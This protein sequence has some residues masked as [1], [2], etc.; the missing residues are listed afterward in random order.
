MSNE[1]IVIVMLGCWAIA[2]IL[3]IC[4]TIIKEDDSINYGQLLTPTK[5]TALVV[6]AWLI[7]MASFSTPII[8]TEIAKCDSP[9]SK[10]TFTP[11]T[12]K[13]YIEHWEKVGCH[14]I[15]YYTNNYTINNDGSI[16][17]HQYWYHCLAGI[18]AKYY[19]NDLIIYKDCIFGEGD[20]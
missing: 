15:R 16:T 12:A 11:Y 7:F 2:G 9:E 14:D 19:D 13:Y 18:S 4:A 10:Y 6:L 5:S 20:K 8:L 3:F 17:L 1:T